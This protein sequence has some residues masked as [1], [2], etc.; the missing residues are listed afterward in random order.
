M[1][2]LFCVWVFRDMVKYNSVEFIISNQSCNEVPLY[3]C[4][5]TRVVILGDCFD[6]EVLVWVKKAT[7]WCLHKELLPE[8]KIWF[9]CLKLALEASLVGCLCFCCF[10]VEYS[11]WIC[12]CSCLLRIQF[13]TI[14]K[15]VLKI[16][17]LNK[18][19]ESILTV[20]VLHD[21]A[22]DYA[23]DNVVC[24]WADAESNPAS[25]PMV[26]LALW[27][28]VGIKYCDAKQERRGDAKC[29]FGNCPSLK[30]SLPVSNCPVH[31]TMWLSGQ[32]C[33]ARASAVPV[34]QCQCSSDSYTVPVQ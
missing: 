1:G 24:C 5:D 11:S 32:C 8:Q 34:M 26:W 9:S 23:N 13:W 18:E 14:S 22:D 28:R 7:S 3:S 2:S 33:S 15:R 27:S 17:I 25:Q 12:T 21:D 31:M 30:R 10:F 29:E 16:L 4:G 19:E 20:N 6:T